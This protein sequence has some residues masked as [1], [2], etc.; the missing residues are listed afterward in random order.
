MPEGIDRDWEA[1]WYQME[2]T[3]TEQNNGFLIYH[4][5]GILS[6]AFSVGKK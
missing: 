1:K 5:N 6:I 2:S 3:R 4:E